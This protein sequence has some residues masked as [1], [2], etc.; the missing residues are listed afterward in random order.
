MLDLARQTLAEVV[1]EDPEAVDVA[2]ALFVFVFTFTLLLDWD[3][4]VPGTH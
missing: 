2:A 4:P 3:E 1:T